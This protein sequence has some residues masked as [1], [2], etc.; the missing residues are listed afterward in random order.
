MSLRLAG[1]EKHVMHALA[2]QGE[3][4]ALSLL[5]SFAALLEQD[6]E[7]GMAE[8]DVERVKAELERVAARVRTEARGI[9]A[10]Q[11]PHGYREGF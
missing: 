6:R 2:V 10:K 11:N 4:A 3:A 7:R 1:I 5:T 8:A 9:V